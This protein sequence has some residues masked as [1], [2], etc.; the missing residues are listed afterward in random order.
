MLLLFGWF[1]PVVLSSGARASSGDKPIG[2][3]Q[4]LRERYPKLAVWIST[5]HLIGNIIQEVR[6]KVVI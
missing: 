3:I 1:S 5:N 2:A 4:N 6:R